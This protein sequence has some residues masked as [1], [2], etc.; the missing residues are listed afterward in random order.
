MNDAMK[1]YNSI[2]ASLNKQRTAMLNDW[3]KTYANYV[4]E[5]MPKQQKQ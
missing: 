3:N 2:N 1:N 4:D 5:Y